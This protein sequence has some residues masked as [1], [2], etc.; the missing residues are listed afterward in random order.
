MLTGICTKE[1]VMA[2]FNTW[3]SKQFRELTEY[4]QQV[5]DK[6][7]ELVAEETDYWANQSFWGLYDE[8]SLMINK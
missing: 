1:E 6:A 8:A 7:T 2:Q 5:I 4:H 3:M